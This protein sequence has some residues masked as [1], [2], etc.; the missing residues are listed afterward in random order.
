MF[1]KAIII[2]VLVRIIIIEYISQGYNF[3]E[4]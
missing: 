4:G 3:Y 1:I 2:G